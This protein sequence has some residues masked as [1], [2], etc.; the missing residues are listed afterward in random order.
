MSE[1]QAVEYESLIDEVSAAL[2]AGDEA[3]LRDLL[4]DQEPAEIALLLESFPQERRATLWR[5][6]GAEADAETLLHMSQDAAEQLAEDI[7]I[8]AI[9]E[10]ADQLDATE[11]AELVEVLPEEVTEDLLAAM[12][13]LRREQVEAVLSFA[14]DTAGRLMHRDTVAV[15]AD[16]TLSVVQRYLA[17]LPDVP[18]NTDQLMVVTR[19]KRFVGVLGVLDVLRHPPETLVESVMVTDVETVT[20][21]RSEHEVAI[22]FRDHDL[23]SL[24]VVDDGGIL[25]GRVVAEDVMDI[26]QWETERAILAHAGLDEDED[27]FAPIYPAARARALWL[28]INLLTALLASWVIGLFEATIDRIV[29]LAVLMPIVASMGGIAGS[30][31]LSLAIRGLALGQIAGSNTPWLLKKEVSIGL[32]NGLLWALIVGLVAGYWFEDVEIGT[33]I[34]AALVINMLVAGFSG[35]LIPLL[36]KRMKIDPALSGAVI[37]TTVTDV[38]GFMSFLGLATVFLL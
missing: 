20:P 10:A 17:R 14:E 32:L 36:L 29:A 11:I 8:E 34:G 38:V 28:G 19:D 31:T 30:Q 4:S 3:R 15:R 26:L 33:V 5:H 9:V 13:S 12:D 18:D 37:L 24:P 6:T 16:A 1:T 2:D 21:D 35:L 23:L 25:L 22:V 27:L 7:G